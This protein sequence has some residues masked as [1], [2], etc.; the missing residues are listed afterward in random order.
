M[1]KKKALVAGA[2][3]IVGRNLIHYLDTLEDWESIG[4]SRRAPDF[5]SRADFISL[6]L[7]DRQSCEKHANAFSG[8]TH[9]LFAA[10]IPTGSHASDVE[11]NLAMLKNLV[12]TV[13]RNST[14]LQRVVLVEGIKYYG[15]HLGPFKTPAKEN[16]PRHM[17]PDFYYDQE[18]FLRHCSQNK[19]WG[20]SALRPSNIC[21]F[22]V[23]SPMNLL[24]AIAIY[25]SL[26]KELDLPLRFPGQQASYHQISE[27]TDAHLL[28]KAIVWAATAK[29]C[30]GEA[31][32]VTNGDFFRWESLWPK[33][34]RYFE[35]DYAPPQSL[36]LTD[37][38]ANKGLIWE[39]LVKRHALR[40]Y[41]YE[42]MV[43]WGFADVVFNLNYDLMSDTGKARRAGFQECIDSEEMFLRLFDQ[44]RKERLIPK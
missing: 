25:A 44:L 6:D 10:Y 5:S 1:M 16:D 30:Q 34:A 35:M 37:V 26:S 9:L 42:E 24:T 38:M 33:F 17:P 15:A 41:R 3:G 28:A 19:S 32:N 29:Q 2:L 18:D 7:L 8:I 11:P 23:G 20:W 40:P 22:A 43:Q 21:G 27:A 13:E 4:I 31:F 36:R 14:Q 12:E 39:R